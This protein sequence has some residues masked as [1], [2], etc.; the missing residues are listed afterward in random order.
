[1]HQ[2]ALLTAAAFVAGLL[3]FAG[4]APAI[5]ATADHPH[6]LQKTVRGYAFQTHPDYRDADGQYYL[7]YRYLR[8]RARRY[9]FQ[10]PLCY[11]SWWWHR[12]DVSRASRRLLRYRRY[13]RDSQG[14]PY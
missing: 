10:I 2:A 12:Y 8:R 3:V 1:M 11:P 9:R 7:L 14:Q 4:S 5:E 6:P 13:G